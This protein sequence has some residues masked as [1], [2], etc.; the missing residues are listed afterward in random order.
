MSNHLLLTLYLSGSLIC[1]DENR[2][3]NST[4]EKP[5]SK[6]SLMLTHIRRNV[7]AA[8]YGAG[9]VLELLC[10]IGYMIDTY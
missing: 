4:Q 6:I 9:T 2:L 10:V 5:R 1:I 8:I 7:G 3:G